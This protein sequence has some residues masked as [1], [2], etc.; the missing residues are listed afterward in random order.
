MACSTSR[1][2]SVTVLRLVIFVT[3]NNGATGDGGFGGRTVAAAAV[4]AHQQAVGHIACELA[5]DVATGADAHALVLDFILGAVF[6][7]TE[8]QRAGVELIQAGIPGRADHRAVKLGV[9]ADG[10]VKAAF[11]GKNPRLLLHALVGAVHLIFAQIHRSAAAAHTDTAAGAGVLLL[12]V[13]VVGVLF[14]GEGQVTGRRP[15][16][17]FHR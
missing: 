5:A 2:R 13:V 6:D 9:F 1:L 14:A 10:D 11:A 17:L 7:I 4:D 15:S 8:P 3:D 16:S 12:R